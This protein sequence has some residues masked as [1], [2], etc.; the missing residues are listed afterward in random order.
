M[1][2]LVM[3]SSCEPVFVQI[4]INHLV[5]QLAKLL[6]FFI[7]QTLG[8]LILVG[9]IAS[10]STLKIVDLLCLGGFTIDAGVEVLIRV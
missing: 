7:L 10:M 4:L 9:R 3:L 1:T 8:D 6:F 2:S 5:K